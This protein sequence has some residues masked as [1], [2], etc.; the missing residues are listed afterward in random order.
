[1]AEKNGGSCAVALFCSSQSA[2]PAQEPV[3]NPL[4]WWILSAARAG[5][6]VG[7]GSCPQPELGTLQPRPWGSG[8]VL[9]SLVMVCCQQ[10]SFLFLACPP[11]Y[12]FNCITTGCLLMACF[13]WT[14]RSR[15]LQ[16]HIPFF[17][18]RAW[19][20]SPEIFSLSYWCFPQHRMPGSSIELVNSFKAK[21]SS[22]CFHGI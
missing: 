3:T 2:A 14:S 18:C 6:R 10:P 11:D 8:F 13:C 5:A 20:S 1:M 15:K 19:W 12:S 22:C 4:H 7:T 9:Y 17:L 16:E 21:L